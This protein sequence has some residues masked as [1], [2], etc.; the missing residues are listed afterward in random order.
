MT[1]P[2]LAQ[3]TRPLVPAA[4]IAVGWFA[5]ALCAAALGAF[6]TSPGAPPVAIGLAVWTAYR[7]NQLYINPS[8]AMAP[9]ILIGDVVSA[10]DYAGTGPAD[11]DIVAAGMNCFCFRS[12]SLTLSTDG[13]R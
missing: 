8:D 4:A 13:S 11:G 10:A 6:R 5:V 2:S 12:R 3:S 9:T 7:N 1:T